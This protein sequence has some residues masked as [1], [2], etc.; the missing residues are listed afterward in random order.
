M[1]NL[2]LIL[3]LSILPLILIAQDKVKKEFDTDPGKKLE[4]ELN[5]GGDIEVTGWDKKVVS[6]EARIRSGDKE[7]YSFD[8]DERSFG[9]KV[10]VTYD[11]RR[12]NRSGVSLDVRVPKEYDVEMETMGGDLRI[13]G[14]EGYFSGETMGGEIELLDLK[15]EVDLTTM[16]GEIHVENSELDGQVKTMGG[17]I[18]LRDVIGDLDASTMG[19]EVSYR[20]VKKRD[21]R[22]D[23]KEIKIS[24][25]GGEI[26]VDDAPGGANVSTMGGEIHIRRARKYVKAKTMGGEIEI[27]EIDGGVKATTMGGDINVNMIGDPDE[28]DRDVILSSM[29]GDIILTVPDGLSMDFDIKLTIT[30]RAHDGY[31]IISDFPMEI[32]KSDNWDYSEGSARRY[33]YGSGKV[34]GGKNKIRIDTINGDIV[35]KKGK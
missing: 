24:T 15:G 19:G 4:I 21:T 17:E 22:T 25:M 8:F 35:I 32:E 27:E 31:R 30:K 7:D 6:I 13:S 18:S 11:G 5:T 33:I 9:I 3:I 26:E 34:R 14:I 1:K 29:G 20:N 10:E 23:A 12:H 2:R 16:G 28:Y